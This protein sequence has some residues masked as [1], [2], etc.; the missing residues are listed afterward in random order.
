MDG[1]NS[2]RKYLAVIAWF[3]Q[4]KDWYDNRVKE[5]NRLNYSLVVAALNAQADKHIRETSTNDEH[6][7]WYKIWHSA[8]SLKI[9]T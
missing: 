8:D 6:V 2:E 3:Y 4:H 9:V 7:E 1:Q 5:I